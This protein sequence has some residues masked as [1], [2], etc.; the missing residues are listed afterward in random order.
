[1]TKRR[2]VLTSFIVT[3]LVGASM[4]PLFAHAQSGSCTPP[5]I[6]FEDTGECVT[7]TPGSCSAG[8]PSDPNFGCNTATGMCEWQGSQGE[9]PA[10]SASED[11][12]FK[13]GECVVIQKPTTNPDN[14]SCPAGWL[15]SETDGNCYDPTFCA[16]AD[17]YCAPVNGRG[18]K[19]DAA[20]QRCV[21]DGKTCA[22]GERLEN[23]ACVAFTCEAGK[24]PNYFGQCID[25]VESP[26]Y[27]TNVVDG[28]FING[29]CVITNIGK[30]TR[31][32]D[33]VCGYGLKCNVS[34]QECEIDT[35]VMATR[36]KCGHIVQPGQLVN[37]LPEGWCSPQ[38][39]LA[40]VL[41]LLVQIGSIILVL[42]LVWTGFKFVAAQGNEEEIRNAR[43]SLMWVVVGGLLLLGAQTIALLIEATIQS[44]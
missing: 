34:T 19:C 32:G 18:M 28:E 26:E 7:W 10:G 11:V 1:M 24:V 38:A 31:I 8:C 29:K 41:S 12:V 20:A 35:S 43:S 6:R 37:L 16:T 40:K 3:L 25:D 22:T 4:L 23:G 14:D 36:D 33:P 15:K 27:C 5:S 30:C 13:G 21:W 17:S 9:C 44:L 42:A 39:V 2:T